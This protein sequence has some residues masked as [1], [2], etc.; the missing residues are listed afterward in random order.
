MT[1]K[2]LPAAESGEGTAVAPTGLLAETLAKSAL[3]VG[4]DGA[5]SQLP[6]G[7]VVVEEAGEVRVFEG[8]APLAPSGL[9]A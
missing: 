9:V 7:G 4:P 2:A 6:F 5:G 3:L 1:V 8:L